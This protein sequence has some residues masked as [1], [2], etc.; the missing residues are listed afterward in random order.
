MSNLPIPKVSAEQ[1]YFVGGVL[2]LGVLFIAAR[3]AV[4]VVD[5]V[6]A[7]GEAVNPISQNNIFYRGSNAVGRAIFGDDFQSWGFWLYD[8]LNP[9]DLESTPAATNPNPSPV[10]L[11]QQSFDQLQNDAFGAWFK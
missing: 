7:F 4:K 10:D 1:L 2:V 6:S 9:D 5:T 3:N 8:A 11:G